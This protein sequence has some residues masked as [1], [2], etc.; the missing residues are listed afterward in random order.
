M[1][2]EK[3]DRAID[4]RVEV[5]AWGVLFVWIG[6]VLFAHLS[7]NIGLIG[8]GVVILGAQL[9]RRISGIKV[10]GFWVVV[11]SLFVVGGVWGLLQVQVGLVPILCIA[12]GL[13]LVVWAV[14][15]KRKQ[16][17]PGTSG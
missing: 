6:V 7:W 12:A 5:G 16:L 11:A 9:V 4:K 10:E 8:V 2:A 15:A 1:A 13:A 3:A 17:R 14:A